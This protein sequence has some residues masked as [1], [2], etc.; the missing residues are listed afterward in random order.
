MNRV[1]VQSSN[2]ASVGY[3]SNEMI[4]EIEFNNNS[5]YQ[6]YDVPQQ[7]Y[8]GLMAAGSHGQYFNQHI[9]NVYRYA[10]V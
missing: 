4:L 9:R 7:E 3:D 1:P 5:I 6:Y 8:D 10:R 2:L